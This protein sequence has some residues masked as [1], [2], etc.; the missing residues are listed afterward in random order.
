M[1][2]VNIS[3]ASIIKEWV[4][5]YTNNLYSWAMYN[6]SDKATAEDI[7][8]ETFLAAFQSINNSKAIAVL[9]RG[10]LEL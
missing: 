2:N 4:D 1:A 8:Q 5:Q 9:K 6:T 3:G 7:V 10:C